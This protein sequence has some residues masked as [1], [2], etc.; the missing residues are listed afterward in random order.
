[1]WRWCLYIHSCTA[2]QTTFESFLVLVCGKKKMEWMKCINAS[3]SKV[4][5][6]SPIHMILGGTY[7][8]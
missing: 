8:T 1:M 6:V 4:V 5:L 7:P 3:V 2:T